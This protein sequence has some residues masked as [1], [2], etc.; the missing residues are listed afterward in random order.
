MQKKT[1]NCI[2]LQ[3]SKLV[4]QELRKKNEKR[5]IQNVGKTKTNGIFEAPF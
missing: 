1:G 4:I 5:K 2:I 3:F